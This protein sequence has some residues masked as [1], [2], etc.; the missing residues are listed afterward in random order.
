MTTFE[1]VSVTTVN[2]VDVKYTLAAFSII[3]Y[4]EEKQ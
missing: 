2:L 1:T 4:P 3:K